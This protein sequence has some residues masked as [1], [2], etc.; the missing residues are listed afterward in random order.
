MALDII[1]P[2]INS[3]FNAM[4][5]MLQ[6]KPTRHKPF[7]KKENITQGDVTGLVGFAAA[8]ISGSVALSF[9]KETAFKLY[10]D[11]VGTEVTEINAEIQDVVGEL[12]NI[13]AGGAKTELSNMGLSY[14]I[15]IPM[16]V[17]GK[18]HTINHKF[19]KPIIV[20]PFNIG[21]FPFTMELS[22]KIGDSK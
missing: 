10:L 9:P 7:M 19:D 2:F 1:N 20:V 15:S 16:V 6:I 14:H 22:I 5:T 4:E 12:T 18:D 13:V 8:N 3:V 21:D 11:M 17:A